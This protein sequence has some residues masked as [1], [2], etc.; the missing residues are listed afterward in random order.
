[1]V[2]QVTGVAYAVW[3]VLPI[4]PEAVILPSKPDKHGATS[5]Y[6]CV[7]GTEKYSQLFDFSMDIA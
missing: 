5:I 4:T 3:C 2:N 1:V 7:G 6:P